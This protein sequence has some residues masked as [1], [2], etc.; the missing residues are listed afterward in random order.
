MAWLLFKFQISFQWHTPQPKAREFKVRI[1][2]RALA[3]SGSLSAAAGPSIETSTPAVTPWQAPSTNVLVRHRWRIFAAAMALILVAAGAGVWLMNTTP[4]S[5][6]SSGSTAHSDTPNVTAE[7]SSEPLAENATASSTTPQPALNAALSEALT[8]R[9]V[10]ALIKGAVNQ[11]VLALNMGGETEE[12]NALLS[13]DEETTTP[14][15]SGGDMVAVPAGSFEPGYHYRQSTPNSANHIFLEAFEIDRLEV[16]QDDYRACVEADVCDDPECWSHSSDSGQRPVTCVTWFDA[17]DYCSWKGKRL[18]LEI[19]WERAAKGT[20]ERIYPWGDEDPNCA[21]SHSARCGR[22]SI[23]VGSRADHSPDGVSDMA[24]NVSE[25]VQDRYDAPRHDQAA[26]RR[27][28]RLR[29]LRVIRGGNY[30]D[31][32]RN[33][34]IE[35]R[36]I[37]WPKFSSET[38]GFRCARDLE[39]AA[40]RVDT[41]R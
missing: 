11:P 12:P 16:T 15:V 29:R 27:E 18:P 10:D 1:Q 8:T 21:R 32:S 26:T 4:A 24:G 25:W 3:R 22:V 38:I 30:S 13:E 37:S 9:V 41:T 28:A 35:R 17:R 23:P 33:L 14:P 19:E 20:S 6:S 7:T 40:S 2:P 34:K 39:T 36:H 5:P 31:P